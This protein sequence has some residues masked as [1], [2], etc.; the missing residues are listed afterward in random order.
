MMHLKVRTI[1]AT[2]ASSSMGGGG[3]G[4]RSAELTTPPPGN[5]LRTP[6]A[7]LM[8][9][10]TERR[11][12]QRSLQTAEAERMA[13]AAAAAAEEEEEEE[14]EGAGSEQ[15][16]EAGTPK[17]AESAG[18]DSK[19]KA[20]GA[21]GGALWVDK[22][23]PEG[24]RDLLSDEKINREVLRA[25]KAWDP[26]VFKKEVRKYRTRYCGGEGFSSSGSLLWDRCCGILVVGGT[27]ERMCR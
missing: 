5:L 16:G 7:T 12:I 25:V 1:T 14:K 26:F 3:G 9:K 18:G 19:G 13:A 4:G 15:K 2:A 6:M 23:A 8:E 21:G 20:A 11:V 10:V 17:R 24:F 22:Y 27:V